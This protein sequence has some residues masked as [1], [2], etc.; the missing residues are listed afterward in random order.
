M[1]APKR[2]RKLASFQLYECGAMKEYLEEM[3]LNGWRLTFFNRLFF[4]FEQIQPQALD[5]SVE[6]FSTAS[7]NDSIPAAHTS[8]YIEYCRAAGWEFV[9]NSG[10]F[11][12][13]VAASES[14][15]PIETDDVARLKTI[16][17]ALVKQTI[18]PI[19]LTPI[20]IAFVMMQN[21]VAA[22]IS[23]SVPF[24]LSLC[25]VTISEFTIF[26]IW[27]FL[28]S[29]TICQVCIFVVWSLKQK[30]RLSENKPLEFISLKMHYRLVAV[31]LIR[32]AVVALA[33]L[34]LIWSMVNGGYLQS[35]GYPIVFNVE[36]MILLPMALFLLTFFRSKMEH[37]LKANVVISVAGGFVIVFV[38]IFVTMILLL[39]SLMLSQ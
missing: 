25:W 22:N 28:A 6:I 3:A 29:G 33:I 23:S 19:V 16:E 2:L 34:M 1:N 35:I 7:V 15:T 37:S 17:K 26:F 4:Y 27:L 39:T 20:L 30:R 14:A 13:F 9:H 32:I 36:P 31:R 10:Q 24:L 21:I 11:V 18:G 12:V 8:E 38:V 5:Y